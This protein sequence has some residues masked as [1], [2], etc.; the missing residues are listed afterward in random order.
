[1][2]RTLLLVSLLA[3][4]SSEAVTIDRIAIVI[5]NSIIKDSDIQ[6][7][8]R[9]VTFLNNQPLDLRDS[10]RKAAAS[11]L[12]DQVFIRREIRLGDYATATMQEADKQLA[13]LTGNRFKNSGSM[14]LALKRYGLTDGDIRTHLQWELSVLRFVDVRF[15][16]A[17]YV[18]DEEVATYYKEHTAQL[19][20]QFPGKSSLEDLQQDIRNT[21][22]GERVNKL[23]FNWLDEQRKNSKIEYLEASLK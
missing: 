6:R 3:V 4:T 23:F 5:G 19:K 20:R 1:M 7:D 12:I 17:V 13:A 10:T 21:L 14:D 22:S 16:P 11:R 2:W 9:V 18:S 8:I 15:R